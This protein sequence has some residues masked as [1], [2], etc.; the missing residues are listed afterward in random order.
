M[1]MIHR[2]IHRMVTPII[3]NNNNHNTF[4]TLQ[5]Q[6]HACQQTH[7]SLTL[8]SLRLRH[9]SPTL[10]SLLRLVLVRPQT[11]LV[12]SER[13]LRLSRLHV[14]EQLATAHLHLVAHR[15]R[16]LHALTVHVLHVADPLH[17]TRVRVS[18]HT[19]VADLPE[20]PRVNTRH[21][22]HMNTFLMASS[23]A[24]YG[25]FFTKIERQSS[26]TTVVCDGVASRLRAYVT[27]M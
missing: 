24:S 11:T 15:H 25:R 27:S 4:H 5:P 17:A 26:G 14:D 8:P 13:R 20:T 23:S 1:I 3:T 6:L 2:M 16:L 7:Q 21:S 19:H 9:V 12:G 22:H 18:R 10:R